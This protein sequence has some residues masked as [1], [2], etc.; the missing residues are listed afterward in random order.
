MN[1]IK[2]LL[3]GLCIM[4]MAACQSG[5]SLAKGGRLYDKWW[6][7]NGVEALGVDQALWAEQSSN[8]RSGADTWRCKE[9]H[10]WDYLGADGAY[11]SGSHYTGFVGVLQSKDKTEDEWVAILKGETNLDHDFS[12]V[13]SNGDMHLLAKFMQEGAVDMRPYINAGKSTNGD[14][15]RGERLYGNGCTA[16]HGDNGNEMLTDDPED[17]AV[18]LGVL[19]NDNPWKIYHK[20]LNGQPGIPE[21]IHGHKL[22]WSD[23]DVA[24]LVAYLQTLPME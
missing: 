12:D 17:E 24:D 8:E 7:E 22:S 23:Q 6:A 13:L 11:G 18:I 10:G 9:C 5:D 19:A 4:V 1:L 3:F 14:T 2:Y 20:A 21:M 15:S 16:C